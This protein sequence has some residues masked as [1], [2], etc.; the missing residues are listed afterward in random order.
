M[1]EPPHPPGWPAAA[2][3]WQG[4]R[5][6]QEDAF[7]TLEIDGAGPEDPPAFLMVL[8]DGMGGEAGGAFASRTVVD[9]FESRFPSASGDV[10]A[11]LRDC[12]EEATGRLR[13]RITTDP[14]LS[15][16]GSTVV[17]VLY[18]G[19]GVSWLSVGDS[20]LWLYADGRLTRLNADH[21]MVP[22]LDRLVENGELTPEEARVDGRRNMLRS[23][24]TGAS[25]EL[26]D[27]AHRS[28]RL[29]P[30]NYLLIASDGLETL[31]DD[32][33]ARHLRFANDSVEAAADRLFSAVRAAAVPG[34]DNVT[35]LLLAG[36][37]DSVT[38][39][40]LPLESTTVVAGAPDESMTVR[41]DSRTRKASFWPR[42]SLGLAA[43][44]LLAALG[45]WGGRDFLPLW[46]VAALLKKCESHVESN[47][48]TADTVPTI[49]ACYRV[50]LWLDP[51]NGGALKGLDRIFK[52]RLAWAR[53][54]LEKGKVQEAGR[55]VEH[56]RLLKP[57]A[58]EVAGLEKAISRLQKAAAD[59]EKRRLQKAAAERERKRLQ[60][61]EAERRKEQQAKE[62][63]EKRKRQKQEQEQEQTKKNKTL[64]PG[65]GNKKTDATP[66]KKQDT[67]DA[68]RGSGT[69]GANSDP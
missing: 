59:R 15:G 5:R 35:F 13:D 21:S 62:A 43:G 11:R 55:H 61:A 4:E 14:G 30:G 54:A 44:I 9:T 12:L 32:E 19:T 36:G 28:G 47:G 66:D 40:V 58:P 46:N 25:A 63:A 51:T 48:L 41:R 45:F 27:C 20:P 52:E 22:V 64:P 39:P 68:A 10:G 26:V 33:I 7:G 18:D 60:K 1:T 50:V 24:V 23:A 53:Q 31:T 49:D 69:G 38:R 42:F 16:M 65:S 29:E 8:A 34:Q 6:Y 57:E 56:L 17:A 3:Q 67:G 37:P 2:R